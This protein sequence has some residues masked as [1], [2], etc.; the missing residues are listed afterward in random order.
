MANTPNPKPLQV[1]LWEMHRLTKVDGC[2]L[3]VSVDS[4]HWSKRVANEVIRSLERGYVTAR[5]GKVVA[6]VHMLCKKANVPLWYSYSEP[7]HKVVPTDLY[8]H[9]VSAHELPPHLTIDHPDMAEL[10]TMV[11]VEDA[12]VKLMG[13]ASYY[14]YQWDNW[15][16]RLSRGYLHF[17]CRSEQVRDR[18]LAELDRVARRPSDAD[19]LKHLAQCVRN[20]E[21]FTFTQEF[22]HG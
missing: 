14:N 19:T 8:T 13:T 11:K 21:T 3:T 22:F 9:W 4:S 20:R 5:G 2:S 10:N 6:V 1:G 15:E 17:S 12:R 18:F 16:G 7:P